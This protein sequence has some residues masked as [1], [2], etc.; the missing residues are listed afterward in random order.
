M[1]TLLALALVS[2]PWFAS[3]PRAVEKP[4]VHDLAWLAG[5][6]AS[7]EQ[8]VLTEEIWTAPKGGTLIGLNR[9]VRLESD[10]T[11]S[12]EF[13][14]IAHDEGGLAYHASP[15]GRA[16]TPFELVELTA[17]HAAFENL[18]NDF[19]KRILYT[20]ADNGKTLHAR[21]EGDGGKALEWRWKRVE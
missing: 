20:L 8:G 1:K 21:V 14:R 2:V 5:H 9:G 15:G 7:E 11:I 19:P 12:F 17:E 3:A 18:A 10:R 16:A 4:T 6:W 13:L